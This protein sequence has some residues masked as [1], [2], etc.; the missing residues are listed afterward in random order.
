MRPKTAVFAA[1]CLLILAA[2]AHR[3]AVNISNGPPLIAERSFAIT[4]KAILEPFTFERVLDTLVARSG[5][6]GLTSAQLYRQ[7]F[8]TQNPKPG[9][10]DPAGPHC[11]DVP[12]LNGFARRCPTAE[13]SLA[14]EPF[15]SGE[16]IPI[17]IA[18]RFD[19][20]APDGS[21]CGQ[22]RIVFA[23]TTP[24][25]HAIFEAF[26][27]NPHPEKGIEGCRAVAQFWA[28][29]SS[30]SSL[31]ERRARLETFFFDGLPGFEPV[32]APA[33]YA[34]PGGVRTLQ[35]TSPTLQMLQFRLVQQCVAGTCTMRFVPDVLE[36]TP[37]GHLLDAS[38]QSD[39]AVRFRDEFVRQLPNLAIADASSYF[40]NLPNEYLLPDITPPD[41]SSRFIYDIT[42]GKSA[43]PAA[44]N[45]YRARIQSELTKMGSTLKPE[46]IVT[47]AETLNCV[48]CHFIFADIGNGV[49]FPQPLPKGQQVTED[50]LVDGEA[51][52]KTRYAVSDVVSK[53]FLPNRMKILKDFLVSGKAPVHS[54]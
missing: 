12:A 26:L 23:R 37:L 33:H 2:P 19:M 34:S 17:E 39:R 40:I 25:L 9:L 10:A 31:D 20:A 28:D 52:A 50:A 41:G 14:A 53:I 30:V 16:Y 42:F 35:E 36:N 32:V 51:G 54:Q 18:N 46:D 6:A 48:G 29:L 27:P 43:S 15:T 38:D 4:D 7:W 5:V 22:Y 45:A 24:K 47:R 21:N 49:I 13:G 1:V 44:A 8:D 11:D 3:R